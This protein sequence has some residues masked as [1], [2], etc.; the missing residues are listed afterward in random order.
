MFCLEN[1]SL[2]ILKFH[3]KY[4]II[5]HLP[6]FSDSWIPALEFLA[7]TLL[8]H[9]SIKKSLGQLSLSPSH[10]L[11]LI[12]RFCPQLLYPLSHPIYFPCNFMPYLCT[13]ASDSAEV[14]RDPQ[15]LSDKEVLGLPTPV[16]W[17]QLSNA[18]FE[19]FLLRPIETSVL[20]NKLGLTSA[21]S[22]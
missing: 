12:I 18:A 16:P 5:A 8:T 19:A 6:N 22:N 11:Y 1:F 17:L 4:T 13:S 3:L 14:E 9:D 10:S 21:H 7:L 2:S 20:R 15:G